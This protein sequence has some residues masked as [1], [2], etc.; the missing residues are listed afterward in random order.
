MTSS[1][2]DLNDRSA[3]HIPISLGDDSEIVAAERGSRSFTW[4][5]E[6]ISNSVSLSNTLASPELAISLLS[7]PALTSKRLGV[8][9]MPTMAFIIDL[10][11]NL[12]ILGVAPRQSDGLYYISVDCSFSERRTSPHPNVNIVAMMAKVRE[13]AQQSQDE[14]DECQSLDATQGSEVFSMNELAD[15]EDLF[16]VAN[17]PVSN[18]DHCAEINVLATPKDAVQLWHRWLAHAVSASQVKR[19]MMDQIISTSSTSNLECIPCVSGKFK[20]SFRGSLST[21]SHPSHLHTDITT[22][23]TDSHDGF[24]YY[25][26]IVDEYTRFLFTRP[27]RL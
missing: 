19:L 4:N 25:I 23:G 2:D 6:G 21:A 10:K 20:K 14:D 5:F 12:R 18:P 26:V 9:F 8:L 1:A 27:L 22:A 7:I 11:E 15:F 17:A 3:C 24:Q 16:D 13:I